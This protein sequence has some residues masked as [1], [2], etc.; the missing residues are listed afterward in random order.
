MIAPFIPLWKEAPF[1]RLLLPFLAGIVLQW[2]LQLPVISYWILL[3]F[4]T[5]AIAGFRRQS[6]FN[7][8]SYA[9]VAGICLQAMLFSAGGSIA[10]YKDAR[11]QQGSITQMDMRSIYLVVE[12]EEPPVKKAASF[13]AVCAVK[14]LFQNGRYQTG[15]GRLIVYFSPAGLS[16]KVDYGSRVVLHKPLQP[17]RNP[18]NPGGFNYR[19]YCAFQQIYYQVY[20][21]PGEYAVLSSRGGNR[22]ARFLFAVRKHVVDVLHKWVGGTAAGLAEALL[23]GYKDELD[24][25]L[26]QS[27]A[28]TGV[29]HIIAISGLHL[30][31]I[32]WVLTQV[33]FFRR[34]LRPRWLEPLLIVAGLWVFSLLTGGS[35]SVM[36]S[37]VMFTGI[38][39]GQYLGKRSSVYNS[40]A[41]SAF[42]LLCYNPFW[43]W[44]AGFQ[45]S[46]LAL[47]SI[48]VFMRPVQQRL[49]AQNRL[50]NGLSKAAATTLAAQILAFPICTFLFHQFPV[51]FLI[52]N[53]VTVPLSSLIVL[54]EIALCAT[55]WIPGSGSLLGGAVSAMIGFMNRFVAGMEQLPFSMWGGLN[56]SA[57]Q[58]ALLYLL[59]VAGC[60]WIHYKK[61]LWLYSVLTTAVLFLA[62]R[63]LSVFHVQ[64]QNMLIVYNIPKRGAVDLVRGQQSL[65]VADRVLLNDPANIRNN[66]LPACIHFRM[67]HLQTVVSDKIAVQGFLTGAK[68]VLLLRQ[69]VLGTPSSPLKVDLVIISGNPRLELEKLFQSVT[70]GQVVFDASNSL[71]RIS[72]WQAA[73]QKAGVPAHAVGEKGAFVMNLD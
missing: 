6:S 11:H 21:Q 4:C 51:Y 61:V 68:K 63:S 37:A 28:N 9:A 38:V 58:T 23:I 42:L 15:S 13:K 20:L 39:T 8:Y 19:Q 35:P 3:L 41:A 30:G 50:L 70:A 47:L 65:L 40:L 10:Y 27:Y 62:L 12:L 34:Y 43:L 72:R 64:R 55:Y 48:V 56:I 18:D 45:L 36:R 7:R 49:Y 73:C 33:F 25:D 17:V 60:C 1:L 59:I 2:Y 53:L 44:D 16:K 71:R 5:L 66:I 69:A 31:L 26:V 32:Y 46:Y 29:V 67:H 52:T 57:G 22:Y 24:K 54:T 14:V